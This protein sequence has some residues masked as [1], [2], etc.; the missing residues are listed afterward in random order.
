MATQPI[1]DP[2]R[3]FAGQVA[4]Y[5]AGR[6]SRLAIWWQEVD[7]GLLAIVF[8]LMAIGAM[9]VAA[10]SPA[11]ARRLSTSAQKLPELYFFWAHLRW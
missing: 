11:T 9:A 5:R 10:G 2:E 8:V 7:R 6:R 3:P 1:H 4:R